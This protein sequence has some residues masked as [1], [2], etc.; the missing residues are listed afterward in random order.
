MDVRVKVREQ[1]R[2]IGVAQGV[3][4]SSSCFFSNIDEIKTKPRHCQYYYQVAARSLMQI[5]FHLKSSKRLLFC[6]E[7]NRK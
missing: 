3:S 2:N 7:T 5:P 4:E 1:E 6:R